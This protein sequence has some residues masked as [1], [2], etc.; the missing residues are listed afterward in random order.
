[1]LGK[2]LVNGSFHVKGDKSVQVLQVL[3]VEIRQ[4]QFIYS[5][6]QSRI[7]AEECCSVRTG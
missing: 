5:I 7:K 4:L 6:G 1:M 3:Q 2:Q